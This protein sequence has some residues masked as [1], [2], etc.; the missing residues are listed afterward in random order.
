MA[1]FVLTACG[2]DRPG[3]VAAVARALA[4]GGWDIEDSGATILGGRFAMMLVVAREGGDAGDLRR[5]LEGPARDLDLAVHVDG[6]G[7][8]AAAAAAGKASRE[9]V[10][11][12]VSGANRIGI[13]ARVAEVL[14]A[15][16][17]NVTDL[18]TRLLAAGPVPVYLMR[19]DGEADR[20]DL[21]PLRADL[22]AAARGLG[23]DVRVEK[24]ETAEL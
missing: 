12:S 19:I 11:V 22:E 6:A 10:V 5:A 15:R 9:A 8:P 21:E 2:A 14:A 1:R 3:I 17:V 4:A 24:I 16:G 23:V 18:R 20:I 13:V 7:P